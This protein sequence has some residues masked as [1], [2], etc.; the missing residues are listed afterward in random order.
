M[1]SVTVPTLNIVIDKN[2]D[3]VVA[4]DRSRKAAVMVCALSETP[5]EAREILNMLGL[6]GGIP[7][8]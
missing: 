8:E 6:T 5:E 3:P 2:E 7:E 4:A 1:L